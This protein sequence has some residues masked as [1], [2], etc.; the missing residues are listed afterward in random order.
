MSKELARR[1]EKSLSEQMSATHGVKKELDRATEPA[2]L[3]R[4]RVELEGC[5]IRA[6]KVVRKFN[7]P[8]LGPEERQRLYLQAQALSSL[9]ILKGLCLLADMLSFG[10]VGEE[11][12]KVMERRTSYFEIM[13]DRLIELKSAVMV[14]FTK[15]QRDELR[16]LFPPNTKDEDI[17]E[18][19]GMAQILYTMDRKMSGLYEMLHRIGLHM[20]ADIFKVVDKNNVTQS[21]D[22]FAFPR[23]EFFDCYE[24]DELREDVPI[25]DDPEAISREEVERI[26]R[27]A[28][29]AD[30]DEG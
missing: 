14:K 2:Q 4:R 28:E 16:S 8:K 25:K 13:W 26:R 5:R 1:I 30:P 12:N 11:D 10:D 17:P 22:P 6:E 23:P 24:D 9:G 18:G 29:E 21:Q 7:D 20:D 15:Q 27:E 19:W 3:Q